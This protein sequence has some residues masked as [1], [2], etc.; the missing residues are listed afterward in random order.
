MKIAILEWVCG[1]GLR[2]QDN[3]DQLSGSGH[4]RTLLDEG[5]EMLATVANGIAD[6][7]HEV[8]VVLDK[9]LADRSLRQN[10][11]PLNLECR[12]IE[13]PIEAG[14][15]SKLLQKWIELS[16]DCD[17]AI[18]IAPEIDGVL[19]DCISKLQAD[20]QLRLLNCDGSSLNTSCDKSKFA[21]LLDRLGFS[22]GP[23]EQQ[24]LHP[25][26]RLLSDVCTEW[27]ET[28]ATGIAGCGWVIKPIDGAGC[29]RLTWV[30]DVHS[31]KCIWEASNRP[32][33]KYLVQPWIR[34]QSFSCSAI[35]DAGGS[36]HWLPIIEQVLETSPWT[37]EEWKAFRGGGENGVH[38]GN[39]LLCC[40]P[41][42]LSYLS[43]TLTEPRPFLPD[44]IKRQLVSALG[45]GALG[46]VSFDLVLSNFGRWY[47]IE[48]NSRCTS[49]IVELSRC[50]SGNLPLEMAELSCGI[51]DRLNGTWLS[52]CCA[53]L[54]REKAAACST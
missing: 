4:F 10:A 22:E 30:D 8:V 42:R 48:C 34:G 28:V 41:L 29:D 17:A 51:R 7:S 24:I 50:Y 43:S 18:V 25:P 49:S 44:E 52:S 38:L 13:R 16:S 32:L 5:W 26:T 12:L 2:T 11:N 39:S 27:C 19:Q 53:A 54:K 45:D 47:V 14:T 37:H 6:S 20:S 3:S 35:V 31:A 33:D 46:W 40:R 9:V 21:E 36:W 1:G 15:R 23:G